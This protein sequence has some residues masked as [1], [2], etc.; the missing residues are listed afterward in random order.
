MADETPR[1]DL[2]QDDEGV[3]S[4]LAAERLVLRAGEEGDRRDDPGAR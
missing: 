2:L 3:Q 4:H 1:R